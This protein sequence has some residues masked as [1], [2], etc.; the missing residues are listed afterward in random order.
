MKRDDTV[1]C[2]F[3]Q[4]VNFCSGDDALIDSATT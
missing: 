1:I 4:D 2:I 3:S